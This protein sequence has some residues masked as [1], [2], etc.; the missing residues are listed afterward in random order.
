MKTIKLLTLL[1]LFSIQAGATGYS[2]NMFVAHK[3]LQAGKERN[4]V[5]EH[6]VV[7]RKTSPVKV[8]IK[9]SAKAEGSITKQISDKFS[10]AVTL[11][12]RIVEQGP[13]SLFVSDDE[14]EEAGNTIVSRL[15]GLVKGM[16]FA[17]VGSTS[18]G[19]A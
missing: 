13:S 16:V 9:V 8:Q 3:K 11:N 12:Q 4:V 2:H 17:F 14:E 7:T 6:D 1:V 18:L 10:K 15:V 19:K 5:R